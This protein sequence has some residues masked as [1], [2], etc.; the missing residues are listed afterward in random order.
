MSNHSQITLVSRSQDNTRSTP[1]SSLGRIL[2]V[3]HLQSWNNVPLTLHVKVADEWGLSDR[4]GN[5]GT[6]YPSL[7]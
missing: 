6:A 1:T 7:W 4:L 5:V 2:K 3:N